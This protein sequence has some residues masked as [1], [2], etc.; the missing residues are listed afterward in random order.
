[1]EIEQLQRLLREKLTGQKFLLVLGDVWNE[2]RAKW[3]ELRSLI[4]ACGDGSKIVVTTRSRSIASMMG[5]VPFHDLEAL[6]LQDSL[7]LFVKWAFKEGEEEKHPDLVMIGEEIVKKCR[8]VPLAVKTLA[9]LLFSKYE[10]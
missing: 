6:S 7:S 2:D 4:R 8:G 1:M 10:T 5:T 9:S 3:V